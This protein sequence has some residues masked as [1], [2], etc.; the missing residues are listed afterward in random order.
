M[1]IGRNGH[2]CI[3]I[4]LQ[5]KKFPKILLVGRYRGF[6]RVRSKFENFKKSVFQPQILRYKFQTKIFL[7]N[8]LDIHENGLYYFMIFLSDQLLDGRWSS[9]FLSEKVLGP[10]AQA[11]YGVGPQNFTKTFSS[12]LFEKSINIMACYLNNFL[13]N[14]RFPKVRALSTPPRH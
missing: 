13:S 10:I 12:H 4:G 5:C 14:T 1:K 2:I 8:L 6:L 7:T 11:P 3:Q 9:C